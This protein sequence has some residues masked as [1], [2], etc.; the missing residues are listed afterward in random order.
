MSQIQPAE[1]TAELSNTEMV[2]QFKVLTEA[3]DWLAIGECRASRV[4]L[5][6]MAGILNLIADLAR[7]PATQTDFNQYPLRQDKADWT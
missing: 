5:S 4:F 2:E 1:D 6:E 3:I 7:D